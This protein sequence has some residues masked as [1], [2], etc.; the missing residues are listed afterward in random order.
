MKK[1]LHIICWL[2][3][4][5]FA[6]QSL[7]ANEISAQAKI[8]STIDPTVGPALLAL[9][10]L[11]TGPLTQATGPPQADAGVGIGMLRGARDSLTWK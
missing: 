6:S 7:L 1:I 8:T 2:F 5:T 3:I 9:P 11:A 10:L 4:T